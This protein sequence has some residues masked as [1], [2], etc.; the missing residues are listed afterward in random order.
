MVSMFGDKGV[1]AVNMLSCGDTLY[2]PQ[3]QCQTGLGQVSV[4]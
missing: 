1:G 4:S 3:Q 2:S